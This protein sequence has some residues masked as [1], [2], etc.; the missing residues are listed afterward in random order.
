MTE[1]GPEI[2]AGDALAY[3]EDCPKWVFVYLQSSAF[4]DWIRTFS[5]ALENRFRISPDMT[6][7]VFP[8]VEPTGALLDEFVATA[9]QLEQAR[10]NHSDH[11]LAQLYDS[12]RMPPDLREAHEVID[13]LVDRVFGL[14]DPTGSERALALLA[15]HHEIVAATTLLPTTRSRRRR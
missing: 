4:T 13:R 12:A 2:I 9:E 1:L 3:I 5:G 14:T 8:F 6:Y 15:K 7:N 11:T 10:A